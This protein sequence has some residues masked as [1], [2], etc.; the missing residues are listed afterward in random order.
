MTERT[1]WAGLLSKRWL[2]LQ[3][4]WGEAENKKKKKRERD[5]K[6]DG[7]VSGLFNKARVWSQLQTS[8]TATSTATQTD[9]AHRPSCVCFCGGKKEGREKSSKVQLKPHCCYT[10]YTSSDKQG[11]RGEARRKRISPERGWKEKRRIARWRDISKWKKKRKKECNLA[12]EGPV[13]SNCNSQ[14]I[15]VYLRGVKWPQAVLLFHCHARHWTSPLW[16]TQLSLCVRAD[17]A[18]VK[19][20]Q[21]WLLIHVLTAGHVI[22]LYD[23]SLSH[24]V[25]VFVCHLVQKNTV[26]Q[27]VTVNFFKTDQLWFRS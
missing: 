17:D 21:H 1:L 19:I 2:I 16:L 4:S 10:C 8:N 14:D 24:A 13:A 3:T 23:I 25:L 6:I 26:G 9:R 22:D 20:H 27:S 7:W 12:R 18:H 5:V 11:E 15:T